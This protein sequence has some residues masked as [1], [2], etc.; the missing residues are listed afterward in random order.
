MQKIEKEVRDLLKKEGV[1]LCYFKWPKTEELKIFLK[2][3]LEEEV[4]EKY[5]LR[6]E[7]VGKLLKDF[8]MPDT[9]YCI[10][11]NYYK[12]TNLKGYLEKKRRQL[13]ISVLT[14]GRLNKRQNGRRFKTEGEPMF[15]LN[16][17]DR[18]GILQINSPKHSNDRVY[19][20]NGISPCLNTMQGGDRQPFII[21]STQKHNSIN[22]KGIMNCLPSAMGIVGGH[23]PMI[24]DLKSFNLRIR[25]LTPKE[26]FRLQGFL[27][28]E[29]NLEGIS[30]TQLY[31]LAGNGQSVNVVEKIFKEMFKCNQ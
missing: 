22:D 18:H 1:E 5:Y 29:I 30:N 6:E 21:S 12:G 11:S 26:C 15:T 13:V 28:D 27:N 14:P 3:I 20:D 23:T 10:D 2:D 16:T 24:E 19:S 4:D 31:K 17:Q 8:K 9:S 7:R 25:K